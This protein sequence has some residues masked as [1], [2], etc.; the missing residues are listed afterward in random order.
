VLIAKYTET[1]HCGRQDLESDGCSFAPKQV[2]PSG[3]L[4]IYDGSN[5]TGT[6]LMDAGCSASFWMNGFTG[7]QGGH[8][9]LLC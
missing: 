2:C 7:L 6:G 4:Y 5:R 3:L 9:I 8:L 1:K